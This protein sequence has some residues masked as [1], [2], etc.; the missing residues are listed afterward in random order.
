[1]RLHAAGKASIVWNHSIEEILGDEAG[2]TGVRLHAAAA[3]TATRTIAVDGVFI[4]VGHQPNT[5]LFDK[6][7]EM[8]GGYIVVKGG[9]EGDAT[10]TSIPGVF[11][12]GDVADHVYRQ[13][14]TSAGTGCMAAL[15]ADKYLERVE[16]EAAR[17]TTRCPRVTHR[18]ARFLDSIAQVDAASWNAWPATAQ[19]F[20]RHE[21][22]LALEE[23]G[24]AVPR[25]GWTARHLV[26]DDAAGPPAGR[27]ALVSQGAFA[28]RIRVRLLL[29]QCLCAARAALLSEIAVG[30]AVHSGARTAVPDRPDCDADAKAMSRR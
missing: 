26:I 18:P 15:D 22:L 23:S 6:Q 20:L 24:C 25:T 12:A 17:R 28:R 7:L 11:A 27:P 9:S 2:V 13:A 1:M 14:V 5:Q 16:A 3:G 30:R 29:G 21:F 8:R 4:A 19:P 10:A